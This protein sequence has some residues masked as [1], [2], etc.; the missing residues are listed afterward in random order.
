MREFY[1]WCRF[2]SDSSNKYRVSSIKYQVSLPVHRPSSIVVQSR[3]ALMRTR[4]VVRMTRLLALALLASIALAACGG[5]PAT[6]APAAG[7]KVKIGFLYVGPTDDYG[8]N[9]AADQG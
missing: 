5:A 6:T 4:H 8:Y 9:Y 2:S 3:S 7:G 1:D